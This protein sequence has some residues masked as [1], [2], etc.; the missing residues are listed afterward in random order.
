MF[1][2][3]SILTVGKQRPSQYWLARAE[4]CGIRLY[5]RPDAAARRWPHVRGVNRTMYSTLIFDLSE[6]FI[7]GLTGVEVTLAPRLDL[8]EREIF[9]AMFAPPTPDFFCGRMTEAAWLEQLIRNHRWVGVSAEELGGIMRRNFDRRVEGTESLVRKLAGR[10]ELAMLSDHAREWIDY[11]R[12]RHSFFSL[13]PH[14]FFSFDLGHTKQE[15][16]AFSLT[17]ERLGKSAG[18][19]LFVDDLESN[20]RVARSVGI[21]GIQFRNTQQAAA[22]LR[23]RGIS[24]E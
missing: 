7:S 16:A 24:V 9:D 19:C 21:E 8:P 18:E 13:F 10:Y 11:I 3:G 12:P 1:P 23:D 5:N 17:L 14:Q 22:A 15:R 20:L 6:V 4:G 2:S